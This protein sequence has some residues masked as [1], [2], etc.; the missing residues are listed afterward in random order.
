[1]KTKPII[2]V[3]LSIS[4]TCALARLITSF[5]GWDLLKVNS[6]YIIIAHCGEPTPPTPGVLIDNGPN[7]DSSI[8][9]ISVLKGTNHVS[10][11]QLW[12]DRRIWPGENYLVF[13]YY[14]SG[15]YQAFEEYRVIPLGVDFSTNSIAGKPLDEQLQILF[16]HAADNLNREIQKDEEEKHRIEAGLIK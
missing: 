12:T 16:Q 14:D 7:S 9:V 5:P 10:S 11:S 6:P 15:V 2:L 1:M 13:G 8:E 3:L 4:A